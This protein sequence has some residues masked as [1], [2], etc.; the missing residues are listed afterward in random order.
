MA[1]TV[2]NSWTKAVG[3]ALQHTAGVGVIMNLKQVLA[4]EQQ[5]L[6]KYGTRASVKQL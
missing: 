1:N 3:V 2:Y 4:V 5:L 6:T